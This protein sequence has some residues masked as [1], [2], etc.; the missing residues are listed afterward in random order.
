MQFLCQHKP[1]RGMHRH[2]HQRAY[3]AP[4]LRRIRRKSTFNGRNGGNQSAPL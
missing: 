1:H 2:H 3:F 4:T